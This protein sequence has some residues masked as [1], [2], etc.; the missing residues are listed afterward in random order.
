MQK[1]VNKKLIILAA[2][3]VL[4]GSIIVGKTLAYYT[5]ETTANNVITSGNVTV[6]IHESS[7][8]SVNIL[9]GDTVDRS[10][11]FENIGTVPLYLRV[12]LTKR[13]EN[14]ELSA[15]DC[16]KIDL[17]EKNWTYKEGYYYY[18]TPLKAGKT[19]EVLFTQLYFDGKQI[20]NEY[21][22]KAFSLDIDAFAVQSDNNG[23]TVWNAVGWPE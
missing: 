23:D 12:Q 5:A 21:L 4:L 10:V 3:T 18:N 9:P 11:F 19:T 20:D 6:Q 22:G 1:I 17:N 15:D 13:V 2:C 7:V 16:I 8:G 14:S